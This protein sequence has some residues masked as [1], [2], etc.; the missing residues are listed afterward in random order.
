MKFELFNKNV[1]HF[2]EI[3]RRIEIKTISWK[4]AAM[5][6][7]QRMHIS[8]SGNWFWIIN[9]FRHQYFLQFPSRSSYM[10]NWDVSFKNIE[11][12]TEIVKIL[13]KWKSL[14]KKSTV[15]QNENE[16]LKNLHFQ[17]VSLFKML[18]I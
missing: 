16:T 12:T 6:Q 14:N 15:D 9:K 7:L 18:Q 5:N 2:I 4:S 3:A 1:T 17:N 10:M 11:I 13:K 8:D